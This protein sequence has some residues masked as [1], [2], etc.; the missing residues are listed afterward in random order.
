MVLVIYDTTGYII[1]QIQSS[2]AKEPVGV[3][4]I[5]LDIPAGKELVS[6]D[7]TVTPNVPVYKDIINP[8]TEITQL[9]AKLQSE[10]GQTKTDN[11]IFVLI[12]MAALAEVY[13]NFLQLKIQT[14]GGTTA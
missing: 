7:V 14:L 8:N 9:L 6:M 13:E 1:S 2:N 4:F 10:L 11:E 3:P 12:L 5:W